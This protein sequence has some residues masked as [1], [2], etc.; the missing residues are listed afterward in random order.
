MIKE[1]QQPQDLLR[2]DTGL[3][4]SQ[5]DDNKPIP[6][7]EFIRWLNIVDAYWFFDNDGDPTRPH[8]LLTSGKHSDGFVDCLKLLKYP[9][10]MIVIVAQ[11]IKQ[12]RI[13]HDIVTHAHALDM[14]D[15]VFGSPMAGISLAYEVARQIRARH[16]FTEK[17]P[18]AGPDNP[19]EPR[20]LQKRFQIEPHHIVLLA[21]ELI[22]TLTTASEQKEVIITTEGKTPNFIPALIVFFNRSGETSFNGWPIISAVDQKITNWTPDECP[23]CKNGSEAIKPKQN[24]EL[25]TK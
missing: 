14:I 21:E 3:I 23:L 7:D 22:T 6:Q 15:W 11:L 8:A 25:L 5:I 16:G 24:W 18:K 9:K 20:K 12:M 10:A 1:I 13:S 19:D 2:F 17:N 4:I